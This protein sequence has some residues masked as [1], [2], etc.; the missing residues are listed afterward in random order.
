MD[1]KD[2]IC[3][4]QEFINQAMN[5][6]HAGRPELVKAEMTNARVVITNFLGDGDD[7]PAEALEE[8]SAT[9]AA[10]TGDDDAVS[11]E[12]TEEKTTPQTHEEVKEQAGE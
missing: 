2:A 11:E 5:A 12:S 9:A 4:V 7:V 6:V 1:P 8:A 10:K 3:Q